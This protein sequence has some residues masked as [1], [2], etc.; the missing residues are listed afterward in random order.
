MIFRQ[1]PE[2]IDEVFSEFSVLF[3]VFLLT[4]LSPHALQWDINLLMSDLMGLLLS[5][6]ARVFTLI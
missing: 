6:V 5:H 4:R 1:N 3:S 2:S